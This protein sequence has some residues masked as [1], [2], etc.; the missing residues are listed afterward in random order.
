LKLAAVQAFQIERQ[1]SL[2]TVQGARSTQ[3][4]CFEIRWV[5]ARQR[6][7]ESLI[8]CQIYEANIRL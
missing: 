6:L 8:S 2:R 1:T 4:D 3:G 7:F 5:A